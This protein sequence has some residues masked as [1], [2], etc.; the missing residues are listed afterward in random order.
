MEAAQAEYVEKFANPFPAAVRGG[1]QWGQVLSICP[2]TC[3]FFL[4]SLTESSVV[5]VAWGVMGC[6]GQDLWL[7]GGPEQAAGGRVLFLGDGPG[8]QSTPDLWLKASPPLAVFW[9]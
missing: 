4:E 9:A 8:I 6:P 5:S 2:V 7:R 1:A 3:F